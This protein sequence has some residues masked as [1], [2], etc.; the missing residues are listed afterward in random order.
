MVFLALAPVNKST[1][2]GLK[3]RET[4]LFLFFIFIFIFIIGWI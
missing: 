3:E 4:I 2:F 1:K